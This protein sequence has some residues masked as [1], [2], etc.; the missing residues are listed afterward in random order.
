MAGSFTNENRGIE[1][2]AHRYQV[3]GVL[4][5]GAMG[6]AYK[7][8]DRLTGELVT[9]KKGLPIKNFTAGRD[10]QQP[11]WQALESDDTL[12]P[13][14]TSQFRDGAMG[15]VATSPATKDVE[16]ASTFVT[17]STAA[18]P[19]G[20][21]DTVVSSVSGEIAAR[22][23]S[24][25]RRSSGEA[26][27]RRHSQP[28]EK[29]MLA[30]EFEVLAGLRHPNIISVLDY[31][32]GEDGEPYFTMELV[33]DGQDL[34]TASRQ[35]PLEGRV[36]MLVQTLEA[37][38]YLHRR[39]VIHRDLKPSN[40]LVS[41][42]QVKV[43][44]FGISL[45]IEEASL[46]PGIAGTYGYM[47][48]ELLM[49]NPASEA[50]DL[51][52]MGVLSSFVIF[53]CRPVTLQEGGG[54]V[55]EEIDAPQIERLKF[56]IGLMTRRN[57]EERPRS[58]REALDL[59]V[60]AMGWPPLG[61]RED[62]RESFLEAATF[63]GRYDELGEMGKA[64]KAAFDGEG[65]ALILAGESGV[66][67][68]RLLR[69]FRTRALVR[70]ALVYV[71]HATS[72]EGG[73]YHVWQEVVR[74][75]A[76]S[77]DLSPLE[78]GVVRALVPDIDRL[79]KARGE[80]VEASMQS[81]EE[82]QGR[83]IAVIE[84][85][86]RRQSRPVVLILEDLHWA[87]AE[88]VQVLEVLS[89]AAAR[90]RVLIVGSCRDDE[91]NPWLKR[92]HTVPRMKLRR[93]SERRIR[94]L[95]EA[96]LGLSARDERFQSLLA[97][98]S[99]GNPFFIVE[100]L[101]AWAEL[102]GRLDT[103]PDARLPE[104]L[105]PA[106]ISA[107]LQ[108]RL[109]ALSGEDRALLRLAAVAGRAL[110]VD[111]LHTMDPE[112][113]WRA[114]MTRWVNKAVLAIED[115]VWRFAHDKI[116]EQLLGEV[117]A[118]GLGA[119]LHRR[120]ARGLEELYGVADEA[121]SALA[122]HWGEAGDAD[123]EARFA[124]RAGQRALRIGAN[125]EAIRLLG[126]ALEL[127]LSDDRAP[128]P[129]TFRPLRYLGEIAGGRGGEA[130]GE[131]MLRIARI[132]GA[133]SEAHGR[134]GEHATSI[135]HASRA[136]TWLDHSM[137]PTAAEF[138]SGALAQ[139]G[140]RALQSRFPA[141]YAR[142]AGPDDPRQLAAEIQTRVTE[143]CIYTQDNL[144]LLWSSLRML[145]L[146][147]PAG[148]SPHLARAYALTVVL[149]GL[150][151]LHGLAEACARRGTEI[152]EVI[153]R[154]YE[155]IFVDMRVAIYRIYTGQWALVESLLLRSLNLA[156]AARN[157][158]QRLECLSVLAIAECFQGKFALSLTHQREVTVEA[159]RIGDLQVQ[160][161]ANCGVSY[162]LLRTHQIKD[163]SAACAA[164]AACV[165]PETPSA[166]AILFQGQKALLHLRRQELG[167]A[168]EA[169]DKIIELVT[170]QAPVAYWT[171]HGMNAAAEV[172][173]ALLGR[174]IGATPR[175]RAADKASAT[176]A[177]KALSAFGKKVPFS[178]PA[179]LRWEGVLCRTLGDAQKASALL[180]EAIAAAER[181]D[182]P[183]DLG[184]AHLERALTLSPSSPEHQRH[185]DKA[186]ALLA[187]LG[188]V[189]PQARPTRADQVVV[190]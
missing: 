55:P 170:A 101:R 35:W 40:V 127:A 51:Y 5:E 72:R 46:Q 24:S 58:A 86:L 7:V 93:L 138:V 17:A 75:L 38:I 39:G 120:V 129:P 172:T 70:G 47:A 6:V 16:T 142:A 4:G 150:V 183:Y 124:S 144:P 88:S 175:Q 22:D 10:R 43:L 116:R 143:A 123:K 186:L 190:G 125:K 163:A 171:Y 42:G 187:P 3:T 179:A 65:G 128:M 184:R 83:L 62:A 27:T 140:L 20:G 92:L 182:M 166:D 188:A 37:L 90:M 185:L 157:V 141:A 76:L 108:S 77:T 115:G 165:T 8:R 18:R 126:R 110:D 87:N 100:M 180:D 164:A 19:K 21:G 176:R 82:A 134:Y 119:V 107:L 117:K 33:K 168:R 104:Q 28:T 103:V 98:Q 89:R 66:G 2:I 11:R 80:V 79:V 114:L 32:F 78:V 152:A 60:S 23:K 137:P 95:S 59:L 112:Q 48:P 96:I 122:Y 53:G 113:G 178:Q 9:L 133:L 147:S 69:E 36:E 109:D 30:R 118:Q 49:G 41:G 52:S 130:L 15:P 174:Q 64:L 136:L 161:W 54:E 85:M 160:V 111:L 56:L 154:D 25:T 63:V 50:S 151:P 169:A 148:P 12:D 67:K 162:A 99:K 57:P 34:L 158:R 167:E 181:L 26:E 73:P 29:L 71:G 44:D 84:D 74:R 146:G 97:Q 13:E 61:E 189:D 45:R 94:E 91:E 1:T 31:G 155:R 105:I 139:M 159:A 156:T 153:D 106:G 81:V 131:D 135:E 14:I 132:E 177:C 102:T 121:L 145:N 173:L 149:L 68:S